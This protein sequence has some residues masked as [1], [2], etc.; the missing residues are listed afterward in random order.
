MAAAAAA[1]LPPP[2]V[3]RRR[4]QRVEKL[5]QSAA[6][7]QRIGDAVFEDEFGAEVLVAQK[8][9]GGEFDRLAR[10]QADDFAAGHR[11]AVA[12]GLAAH[13]LEDHVHRRLFEIGEIDR[14]LRQVARGQ[15]HA[16]RLHVAEAAAGEADGLGDASWR[17]RRRAC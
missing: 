7:G 17:W 14:H 16:H 1:A 6:R 11:D 15:H 12:L 9:F 4:G 3:A 10:N 5:G 13:G 8:V 2:G